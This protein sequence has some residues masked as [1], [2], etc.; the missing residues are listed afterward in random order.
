MTTPLHEEL[1]NLL[2]ETRHGYHALVDSVPPEAYPRP[3]ANPAWTVGDLLHHL[4]FG[5]Y[6]V[7]VDVFIIRHIGFFPPLPIDLFNLINAQLAR[8][9][10]LHPEP[11]SLKKTYDRGHLSVLRALQNTSAADLT[12]IAHYPPGLRA[13]QGNVSIEQ[14]IRVLAEHLA[15]HRADLLPALEPHQ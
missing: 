2:E 1:L 7:R 15:E 5:P 3:S 10:N 13:L 4:T 8:R 12:K 6:A 14:A 11:A 9:S